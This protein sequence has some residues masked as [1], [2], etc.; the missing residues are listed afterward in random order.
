MPVTM[1]D[2]GRLSPVDLS[3]SLIASG[4]IGTWSWSGRPDRCILDAGAAEVLAGD[5]AIAGRPVPLEQAKARVHPDDRAALF[6]HFD[7]LRRVGGLFVAEYRTVSATGLVRRILDRGRLI[8]EAGGSVARG[9]GIIIDVTEGSLDAEPIAALL[10]GSSEILDVAAAHAIACREAIDRLG[11]SEL[12]LLIDVLL[13]RL[14][15]E[16]AKGSQGTV[17]GT[18]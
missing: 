18:H 5:H 7:R 12:R 9:Y 6:Q 16:L 4:V 10:P 17:E 2:R 1:I 3:A 8:R 15:Q 14:G 11:N 13:L